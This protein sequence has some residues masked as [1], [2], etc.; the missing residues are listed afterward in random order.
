MITFSYGKS[1]YSFTLVNINSKD[2]ETITFVPYLSMNDFSGL[3]PALVAGEGIGDL[4]PIVQPEL[5]RE[6]RLVE[7][8]PNW[9][10]PPNDVFLVRLGS[11]LVPRPVRVFEEFAAQMVPTLFPNLPT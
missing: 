5:M 4:P 7:I 8:M 9:H 2:T 11:R 3:T 6:G 1:A 10:L